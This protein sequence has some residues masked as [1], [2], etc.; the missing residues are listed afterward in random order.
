[1]PEL[2]AAL[3]SYRSGGDPQATLFTAALRDTYNTLD[4][5]TYTQPGEDR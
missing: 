3:T 5:Y 2:R 4:R 1:V